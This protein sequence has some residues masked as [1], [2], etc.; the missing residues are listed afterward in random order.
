M[1]VGLA[2]TDIK[3]CYKMLTINTCGID[4]GIDKLSNETKKC[5][6]V[7]DQKIYENL[8]YDR[9]GIVE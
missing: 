9:T 6:S 3:T 7:T 4:T 1:E 2:F 5:D 8:I